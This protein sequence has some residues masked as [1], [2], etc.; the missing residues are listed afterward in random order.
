[1]SFLFAKAENLTALVE[2]GGKA[3]SAKSPVAAVPSQT[4]AARF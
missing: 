3:D 2:V 4:L 1:M